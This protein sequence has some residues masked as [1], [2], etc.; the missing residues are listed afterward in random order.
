[1]LANLVREYENTIIR[2]DKFVNLDS[3]D[4]SFTNLAVSVSIA[5]GLPQIY[6]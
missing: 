2:R 5:E 1:M 6:C 4:C 3:S